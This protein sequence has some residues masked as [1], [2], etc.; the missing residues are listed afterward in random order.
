MPVPSLRP[1]GSAPGTLPA[2]T[3]WTEPQP[4]TDPHAVL[5]GRSHPVEGSTVVRKTTAGLTATVVQ[6]C[7]AL[8]TAFVLARSLGPELLGQYYLL[9]TLTLTSALFG[10]LGIEAANS[11]FVGRGEENPGRVHTASLLLT[12]LLGGT[13]VL[14]A[15]AAYPIPWLGLKGRV[16]PFHYMLALATV[17]FIL[18]Q[19]LVWS[20]LIG[21]GHLVLMSRTKILVALLRLVGDMTVVGLLW[22][23]VRHGVAVSR[24]G[25]RGLLIS[26][27]LCSAL[28]A[29]SLLWLTLPVARPQALQTRGL[30]GRLTGFGIRSHLGT[31]ARQLHSRADTFILNAFHGTT[32]VGLY[33]V[34]VQA[35]ELPVLFFTA[36]QNAIFARVSGGD[37]DEA[38]RMVSFLVRLG[39][40]A[41]LVLVGLGL[42]VVPR[43]ITWILGQDYQTSGEAFMV[44]IGGTVA[45]GISRLCNP[46]FLG[47]LKRPGLLSGLA[48]LSVTINLAACALLIPGLSVLGAATA[49]LVSYLAGLV[50]LLFFYC[51]LSQQRLLEV[52]RPRRDDFQILLKALRSLTGE[53]AQG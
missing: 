28:G 8:L 44:L 41:W 16:D 35:A 48:W 51:R 40:A 18:Y 47:Q 6:L 13:A 38:T 23:G 2:G 27:L 29:F 3:D 19:N 9:Y 24:F 34:A 26:F 7:A 31:I 50:I 10:S 42:T 15:A 39:C 30:L 53:A 20:I 45:A 37:R 32:A 22:M 14:L 25:V 46:Y 1:H 5:N 49:S 21:T 4:P 11:V 52:L 12:V 17:P 43:V 33:S 36:I